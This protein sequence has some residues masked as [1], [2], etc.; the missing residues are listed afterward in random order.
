[1][2]ARPPQAPYSGTCNSGIKRRSR[3]ALPIVPGMVPSYR[4]GKILTASRK[5]STAQAA[6]GVE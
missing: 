1:M 3:L 5:R 2:Q 6:S 4:V